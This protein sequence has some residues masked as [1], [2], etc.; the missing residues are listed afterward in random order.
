MKLNIKKLQNGG[1]I[2]KSSPTNNKKL[3]INKE[4]K[5][6]NLTP[7][8]PIKVNP[9]KQFTESKNNFLNL[10]KTQ[11]LLN[12]MGYKNIGYDS[13]TVLKLIDK[14]EGFKDKFFKKFVNAFIPEIF[15]NLIN[16]IKSF[17]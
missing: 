4:L 8:D 14:F 15:F 3:N 9:T 12:F 13:D 10:P 16:E 5:V 7:L 6:N 17:D 11:P 1:L 2:Y